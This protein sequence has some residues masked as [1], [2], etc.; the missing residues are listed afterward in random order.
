MF[1][2]A[3]EF[4]VKPEYRTKL[5]EMSKTLLEPSRSEDGCLSYSFYED[6]AEA[7]RFL[8]FERWRDR[9][10]ID[11]HFQENYFK[12]FAARFPGM[13]EGEADINIYEIKSTE[14][15]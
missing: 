15:V 5:I 8:F 1:V 11:A 13:I 4:R 12:D 6:Q 14:T 10:S 3:G 7:N 2:I 9:A